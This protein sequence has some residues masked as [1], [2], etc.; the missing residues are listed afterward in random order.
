M[1]TIV[2]VL[3]TL[4]RIASAA[5]ENPRCEKTGPATYKISFDLSGPNEQ[6]AIFAS[7][8]PDR[9]D[10]NKIIAK[11][12]ASPVS[13]T[14]SQNGRVYFHLKPRKGPVRIV[15]AR[16][17]DLDGTFNTRD[18]G[19]Y[20]GLDGRYVRWGSIYRSDQLHDLT[21]H[22]IAYLTA[23]GLK[24]VCDFRVDPER[25]DSPTDTARLPATKFA[26]MNID[27]Y[28]GRYGAARAASGA[29][30]RGAAGASGRGGAARAGVAAGASGPTA[31]SGRGGAPQ[32]Y[33]W[34]PLAIPQYSRVLLSIAAGDV[35]VL[36]HCFAGK[37]RTGVMAGL[38]LSLLGVPREVV[39]EDYMLTNEIPDSKLPV[40]AKGFIRRGDNGTD[41]EAI[42]RGSQVNRGQME[43]TFAS[44]D[45]NYGSV[46]AYV[47]KEMGLT[48]SDISMIQSRLLIP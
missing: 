41:L 15:A 43:A 12:A 16:R 34:L 21:D 31:A 42:R 33:N 19:G 47:E 38:L 24:L 46:T 4:A 17:L 48:A 7:S 10:S 6:V 37:D 35:P 2:L 3:F 23:L 28:G 44:I 11:A 36:F 13:V 29:G 20:R 1:R 26:K 40:I 22:D 14:V 9:I 39:L 18:L 27:S 8:S 32:P 45:K 5:V 25:A 30:G